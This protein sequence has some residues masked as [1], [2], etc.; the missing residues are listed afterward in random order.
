MS[1]EVTTCP[2]KCAS[3]NEYVDTHWRDFP[4]EPA[5]LKGRSAAR[6]FVEHA[7]IWGLLY[8]PAWGVA[9]SLW[10]G[11]LQ[12]LSIALIAG[13]FGLMLWQGCRGVKA[14][15]GFVERQKAKA[16]QAARDMAYRDYM[17]KSYSGV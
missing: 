7:L 17:Q 13:G 15:A 4:V 16:V 5:G 12:A 9:S 10:F 6:S 2:C 11:T 14:Y 3:A 8:L 1:N